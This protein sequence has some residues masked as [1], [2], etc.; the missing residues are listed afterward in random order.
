MFTKILI[1]VDLAHK[2]QVP[3]LVQAAYLLVTKDQAEVRLLYVD[4]V[5]VHKAGSPQLDGSA[6]EAHEKAARAQLQH[7]VDDLDQ[8]QTPVNLTWGTREGSAHEQI[9][10]EAQECHADA[11]LLM[12][13]RP[14]L[15]SYFI[16]S[17]AE[18]VVR[19]AGCSVFVI[20]S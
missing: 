11:I 9:L 17:T 8:A 3:R 16:G 1:P 20:R 6:Y 10:E 18:R 7:L 12:S 14:G 19:H 15:T 2:D 5:L 4:P 13:K